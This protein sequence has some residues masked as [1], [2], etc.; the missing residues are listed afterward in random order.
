[1]ARINI[2]N[3]KV[4]RLIPGY[5]FVAVTSFKKRSGEEGHEWFTIWTTD[6][7]REGQVFDVS[8]LLSVKI[9]EWEDKI[10]GEPK[11][12]AAVHVNNPTLKAPD[13]SPAPIPQT[14]LEEAFGN[15]KEIPIDQ[16]APF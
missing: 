7:V 11:S 12:R 8:G 4:D 16:G 1:M 15:V 14:T 2:K 9:E 6:P 13:D 5:G 3:A 10:S